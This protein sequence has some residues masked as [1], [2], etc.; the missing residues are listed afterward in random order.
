MRLRHCPR[1]SSSYNPS[2]APMLTHS[3]A[4]P[5][6]PRYLPRRL[7]RRQAPAP[8]RRYRGCLH[9]VVR[10]DQDPREHA[11]GHVRGRLQHI[12]FPHAQLVEGDQAHPLS[13]GGV[14]GYA[15]RWQAL[16]QLGCWMRVM[17]TQR[18]R[19]FGR[20]FFTCMGSGKWHRSRQSKIS[21]MA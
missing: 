9:L 19:G 6:P 8:A 12:R 16:C 5:R 18:G 17:L 15:P 13:S 21:R 1:K 20:L 4:Y 14:C 7:A 3:P 10:L 11:Q 2:N